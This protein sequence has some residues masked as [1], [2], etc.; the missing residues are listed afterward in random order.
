[1]PRTLDKQ[2]N[3]SEVGDLIVQDRETT[4]CLLVGSQTQ[5]AHQQAA[6]PYRRMSTTSSIPIFDFQA[7]FTAFSDASKHWL[8]FVDLFQHSRTPPSLTPTKSIALL[9]IYAAADAP[10]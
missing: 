6:A 9:L 1:M 4:E 7:T 8:N 10:P 5:S 3:A 2:S